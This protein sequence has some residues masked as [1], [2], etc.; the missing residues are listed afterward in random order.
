[1]GMMLSTQKSKVNYLDTLSGLFGGILISHDIN[2]IFVS[3]KH[4]LDILIIV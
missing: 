4:S 3:D 1:M 2:K